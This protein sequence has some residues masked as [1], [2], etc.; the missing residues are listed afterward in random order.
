MLTSMDATSRRLSLVHPDPLSHGVVFFMGRAVRHAAGTVPR[1]VV[2]EAIRRRLNE[3][4]HKDGPAD[5]AR[6]M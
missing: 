4:E 3:G 2:V 6:R 5:K 1:E